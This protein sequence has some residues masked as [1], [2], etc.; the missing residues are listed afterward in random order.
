MNPSIV[1][2]YTHI[3]KSCFIS[4]GDKVASSMVKVNQGQLVYVIQ[5]VGDFRVHPRFHP[6]PVGRNLG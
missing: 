4:F 3:E 1:S 2:D 6:T 5:V